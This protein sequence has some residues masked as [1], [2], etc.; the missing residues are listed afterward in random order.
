MTMKPNQINVVTSAVLAIGSLITVAALYHGGDSLSSLFSGFTVWAL[1]P[2]GV[3]L[4]SSS[5]ARTRGKAFATLIVSGIA[6]A[7]GVFAYGHATFVNTSSTRAL[8]FLVI[9]FYQLVAAA[10]YIAALFI[11]RI[12]SKRSD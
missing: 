5:L 4:A 10:I 3:L 7:F 12:P 1:I 11:T 8:V 2:Y 9:P 6:A